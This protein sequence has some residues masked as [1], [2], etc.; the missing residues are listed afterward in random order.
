M[1]RYYNTSTGGD[2][3]YY[4]P[5]SGEYESAA[6]PS[7]KFTVSRRVEGWDRATWA[8]SIVRTTSTAASPCTAPTAT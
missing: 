7:G 5:G 1:T 2:Y 8:R 6:T 3:T 4:N